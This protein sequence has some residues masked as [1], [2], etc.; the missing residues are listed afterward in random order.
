MSVD[1]NC[2]CVKAPTVATV[3]DFIDFVIACNTE[4]TRM[5][6]ISW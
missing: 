6:G 2:Q 1:V 5:V 4:T 3:V